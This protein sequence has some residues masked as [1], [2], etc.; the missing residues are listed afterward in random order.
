MLRE[1]KVEQGRRETNADSPITPSSPPTF[2][3]S[4]PKI[5][6]TLHLS[7]PSSWE[8]LPVICIFVDLAVWR[9]SR[10]LALFSPAEVPVATWSYRLPAA[11]RATPWRLGVHEKESLHR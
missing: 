6:P 5:L 8:L 1:E 7:R 3:S 9:F 2:L 11:N 4:A 10:I